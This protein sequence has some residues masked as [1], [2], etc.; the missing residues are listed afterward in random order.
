MN[1]WH[2]NHSL[3]R[4]RKLLVILAEATITSQPSEGPLDYPTLGHDLESL[5]LVAPLRDHQLPATLRPHPVDQPLLL[6]DPIRPD[7]L[8]PGTTILD[9]PQQRLDTVVILH[10]RPRH[11]HRDQQPQRVHQDVAL[12]PLDLLARVEALDPADLGRL[13]RLAVEAPPPPPRVVFGGGR[14]P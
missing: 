1:H 5:L 12:P 11:H 7:D 6:I 8:Q 10:I 13:D 3:T 9:R 2:P 14:P 4:L